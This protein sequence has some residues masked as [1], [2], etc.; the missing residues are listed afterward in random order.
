MV[1]SAF[2]GTTQGSFNE[3]TGQ[4]FIVDAAFNII[5][6]RYSMPVPAGRYTVGIE[7]L[8]RLSGSG[9][10]HLA[11]GPDRFDPGAA[12]LQRGVLQSQEGGRREE[13]ERRPA[14]VVV[15]KGEI[16]S[17]IDIVTGRDINVNR[18][19]AA[20]A[21][22]ITASP[23]GRYS[24]PS[25]PC[26]DPIAAINPGQEILV[27]SFAFHTFVVDTS[28]VPTFATAMLT[29]GTVDVDTGA[30]TVDFANPFAGWSRFF[31]P[32]PY[33]SPF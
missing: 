17:G 31:A 23:P 25:H 19:G 10:V 28:V 21:I 3:Q 30:V 32:Y 20:T 14:T 11:D 2:S 24:C 26:G 16:Q 13:S 27:K 15:N 9:G 12:E 29:T 7:P 8:D 18:F 33:R 4:L 5:D 6:G 22:G 1:S